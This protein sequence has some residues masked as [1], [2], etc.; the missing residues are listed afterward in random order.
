MAF[1]R[2]KTIG[3]L[4]VGVIIVVSLLGLGGCND[5]PSKAAGPNA[6][7]GAGATRIGTYDSRAVAFAYVRSSDHSKRVAELVTQ[8]DHAKQAGDAARVKE[9][10][11]QGQAMQVR[12]YLQGFSNAPVTDLLETVS[13]RLPAVAEQAKVTA[14]VNAAD[15]HAANVELV[16]ITADLVQL[17][18]PDKRTIEMIASLREQPPMALEEAARMPANP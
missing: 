1:V 6:T 12:Q 14:I 2:V 5:R 13:E 17:F 7:A 10:E 4:G 18:N 16:D 8:R 15:Y 3:L 11:A 9:L